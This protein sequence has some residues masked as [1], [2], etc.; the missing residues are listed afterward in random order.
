MKL[1]SVAVLATSLLAVSVVAAQ[2]TQL[3]ATVD[4]APANALENSGTQQSAATTTSSGTQNAQTICGITHLV[5]C[6]QNLGE[7]DKGVLTSPLRLKPQDAYWLAP[8]GAATGMAIAYDSAAQRALGY[9]QN[10]VNTANNISTMGE[11]WVT[12]GESASIYFLGLGLKNPKLAET[13][14]LA[15]ETILVSGTVTG[16]L[17]LATNRERPNNDIANGQGYFWKNPPTGYTWDSSFPSGHA[18]ASMALARV[19]AGEYPHW[20]V[21]IPAYGFAETVSICRVLGQDHFPSDVL[22]GQTIGFLTG[23]YV[24]NHRALYRPGKKGIA[25]RMLQNVSPIMDART[26][27][28]GASISIPTGR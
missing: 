6:V 1:L 25:E 22:V 13:G 2:N 27:S 26:H 19:V 24:L 11:F 5:R 21:M 20:Y 4:A 10:R 3:I 15:A 18:T 9:S 12:G 7:D 17:K 14:R 28:F 23:T 8:L 16:A